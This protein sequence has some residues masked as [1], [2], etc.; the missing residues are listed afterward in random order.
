LPR[1]LVRSAGFSPF[2]ISTES[3]SSA[4][5][6]VRG[7]R[8][9]QYTYRLFLHRENPFQMFNESEI[10]DRSNG[11][12]LSPIGIVNLS[13]T[14]TALS[15]MKGENKSTPLRAQ[16][17]AALR[18]RRAMLP[19]RKGRAVA[20]LL[21]AILELF[22]AVRRTL[23]NRPL[24]SGLGSSAESDIGDWSRLRRDSLRLEKAWVLGV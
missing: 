9:I 10:P 8:Y 17:N 15:D 12:L 21:P 14:R 11:P 6:A 2:G 20:P 19:R 3:V 18:F 13:D 4:A 23:P 16:S 7:W 24:C 1:F 22:P 5:E